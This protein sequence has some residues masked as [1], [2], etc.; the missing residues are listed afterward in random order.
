MEKFKRRLLTGLAV[1]ALFVGTQFFVNRG[2]VSGMPPAIQG[3]TLDGERFDL[4]EFHGRPS[5]IYFW[6]SWCRICEAMQGSVRAVARDHALVSLALQSGDQA[7]VSRYMQER[8][9]NPKV[10][11]D[12]DG[13]IGKRYGIRGVP[14][15]FVLGPDGAIRY[16]TMGYTSELGLRLRLW[17]AGF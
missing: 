13:A 10:L 15:V 11:L 6:A 9:F 3:Q 1:L 12:E 17:L 4:A 7:E 14:A 16:S 2:L 5:I 8:G